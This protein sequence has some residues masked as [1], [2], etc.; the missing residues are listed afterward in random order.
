VNPGL[1]SE[2]ALGELR[3][4]RDTVAGRAKVKFTCLDETASSLCRT[5]KGIRPQL[6]R[7]SAW[8]VARREGRTEF[9][10]GQP[11]QVA[12]ALSYAVDRRREV[13]IRRSIPPPY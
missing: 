10:L 3:Y 8:A 11:G 9:W 1:S 4:L 13:R 12:T 5:L 7:L 2:E 6:A